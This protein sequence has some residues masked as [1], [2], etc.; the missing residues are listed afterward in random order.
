MSRAARGAPKRLYVTAGHGERSLVEAGPAGMRRFGESLR[1][2]ALEPVGLPIADNLPMP[3]D[4][5]SMLVA[6]PA[7]VDGALLAAMDAVL[8]ARGTVWVAVE[9]DRQGLDAWLLAHGVRVGGVLAD[10]TPFARFLG[11][12]GTVTATQVQQHPA[13]RGVV[14]GQVHFAGARALFGT[15]EG[16]VVLMSTSADATLDDQAGPYDIARLININGGR[17]VVIGDSSF[18]ADEGIAL[19][20]NE[21]LA[22]ALAM[23]VVQGVDEPPMAMPTP[24]RHGHLLLLTPS[25]RAALAASLLWWA[26]MLWLWWRI[27]VVMRRRQR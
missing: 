17:L 15:A 11:G 9:P 4:V 3:T 22:T 24:K 6:A 27:V 12:S 19:G 23:W 16:D 20:Y 10:H 8:A 2:R 1:L 21:E 18:L 5:T 25:T 7:R 26:P 14:S 13:M